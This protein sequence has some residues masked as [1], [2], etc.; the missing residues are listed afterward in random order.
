VY[1]N[2]YTNGGQGKGF[3][4]NDLFTNYFLAKAESA[5]PWVST[6][7]TGHQLDDTETIQHAI[8]LVPNGYSLDDSN[9]F[10]LAGPYTGAG[11]YNIVNNN[12]GYDRSFRLLGAAY[13]LPFADNTVI[14]AA[15]LGNIFQ[16]YSGA[17]P[18]TAT[19]ENIDFK[20]GDALSGG[21]IYSADNTFSQTVNVK[22]CNFENNKAF[23][24]GG[25]IY[26]GGNT[27]NV[28]NSNFISNQAGSNG[29]AIENDFSGT[30]TVTGGLFEDNTASG[31]GG[32]IRNYEGTLT[33]S[34]VTFET[35]SATAAG[36][37][38]SNYDGVYTS[39]GDVFSGNHALVGGGAIYTSGAATVN[40][41]TFTNNYTG[42]LPTPVGIGGAVWVHASAGGSYL[43]PLSTYS[44]NLPNNI[45]TT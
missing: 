11:N 21:A 18:V 8:D 12:G 20:N 14:D 3:N 30:T 17:N 29:G 5:S 1:T 15:G 24:W 7:D 28:E 39:A 16:V 22:N 43:D 25:A 9:I 37:A 44:G 42:T 36:G 23:V 35:N 38:I 45:Q 34:G 33:T 13:Y 41:G 31:N 4:T 40:S 10:L 26:N 6:I 27:L 19:F 32:A 2:D